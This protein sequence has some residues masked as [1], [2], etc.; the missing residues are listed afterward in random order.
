[1]KVKINE[2]ISNWKLDEKIEIKQLSASRVLKESDN[3]AEEDIKLSSGY[4]V[5]IWVLDVENLNGRTYPRELGERIVREN[6]I[7]YVLDGHPL[8]DDW[9]VRDIVGVAKN[10]SI[11]ENV[12]YVDLFIVDDSI[13]N[14][15]SE[16]VYHDSFV[17]LSSAGL[18]TIE[19]DGTITEENY[20]LQR[21]C[22]LVIEP[23]YGVYITKNSEEVKES[24]EV[25]DSAEEE[26]EESTD[27][28]STDYLYR[29]LNN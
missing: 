7:T 26:I 16:M 20:E 8:N 4:N 15:I 24:V 2:S 17:G 18:G 23:A 1:M 11:K 10:P 28:E 19:D 27:L 22:D 3:F 12:M 9:V 29:Y 13:Q 14:K 25:S 21:Y 5:P 6:K